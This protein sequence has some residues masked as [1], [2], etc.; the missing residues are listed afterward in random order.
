M[1]ILALP[2]VLFA[3]VGLIVLLDDFIGWLK[4]E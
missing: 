2:F 3:L 1:M 4:G